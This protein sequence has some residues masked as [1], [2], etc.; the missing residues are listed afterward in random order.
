MILGNAFTLVLIL[1][2]SQAGLNRIVKRKCETRLWSD[3]CVVE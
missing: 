2:H 3:W 1:I